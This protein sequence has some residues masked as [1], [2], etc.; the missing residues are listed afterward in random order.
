MT[1][2]EIEDIIA[3]WMGEL[4]PPPEPYCTSLDAMSR[5]EKKLMEDIELMAAY[6]HKCRLL[7][8]KSRN[9]IDVDRTFTLMTTPARVRA[10][11][12]AAVLMEAKNEVG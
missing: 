9:I 4:A 6:V 1:T 8:F 2:N 7:L 5:A 10:E 3:N 12:L 11:A